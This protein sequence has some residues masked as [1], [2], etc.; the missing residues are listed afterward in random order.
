MTLVL[1]CM[2]GPSLSND[3]EKSNFNQL[4]KKIFDFEAS[5]FIEENLSNLIKEHLN[6]FGYKIN[7]KQIQKMIEFYIGL[8]FNQ[9]AIIC[10]NHLDGKSTIWKI[11]SKAINSSMINETVST[12]LYL[13]CYVDLF[14]IKC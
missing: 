5:N 6:S 12:L 8:R 2:F 4:L 1:G 9:S 7:Q 13:L 10:G 3:E 14:K 11:I